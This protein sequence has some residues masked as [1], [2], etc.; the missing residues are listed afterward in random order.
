MLDTAAELLDNFADGLI[1]KIP[2]AVSAVS[3]LLTELLNY[4][5]DHQDD[6][7]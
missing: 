3:D 5:A 1:Q 6:T 2:D 7:F 4:L